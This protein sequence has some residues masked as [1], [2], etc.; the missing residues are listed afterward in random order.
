MS[1]ESDGG[2]DAQPGRPDTD[3]PTYATV[4]RVYGPIPSRPG[5]E[6]SGE[7]EYVVELVRDPGPRAREPET[8]VTTDPPEP[9]STVPIEEV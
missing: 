9:W 8:V 6:S 1:S 4:T 2:R 3:A 5:E 7:D